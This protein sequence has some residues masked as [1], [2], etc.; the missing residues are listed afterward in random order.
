MS[1]RFIQVSI[2]LIATGFKRQEEDEARPLQV[3]FKFPLPL[4]IMHTYNSGLCTKHRLV[5][6]VRE[7]Q[8]SVSIGG[9]PLSPT[10]VVSLTSLSSYKRKDAHAIQGF[11]TFLPNAT[12]FFIDA[13]IFTWIINKFFSG[14]GVTS[15]FDSFLDFITQDLFYSFGLFIQTCT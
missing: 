8:P 3:N 2:T 15:Q 11:N 4:H 1:F 5:S 13:S 7:I 9:L 12:H 10:M 6:S 14:L